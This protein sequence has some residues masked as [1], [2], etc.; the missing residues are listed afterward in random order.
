MTVKQCFRNK[1][2]LQ[3]R[4]RDHNPPHVHL[5]GGGFDVTIV[6]ETLESTGNFPSVTLK[7]EVIAYV[8]QHRDELL[9]EWRKWHAK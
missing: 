7:N 3:V 8:E 4:E 6:L 5:F 1:Y 2:V 9:E